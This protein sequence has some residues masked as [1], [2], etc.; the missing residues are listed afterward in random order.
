M[1]AS[2]SGAPRNAPL[3]RVF[4]VLATPPSAPNSCRW[5]RMTLSKFVV[6]VVAPFLSTEK[7]KRVLVSKSSGRLRMLLIAVAASWSVV[8]REMRFDPSRVSFVTTC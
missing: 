5:Y 1:I 4:R 2:Y 8:S 3:P 7:I 6:P